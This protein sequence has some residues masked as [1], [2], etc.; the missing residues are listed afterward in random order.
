ML[1]I[2]PMLIIF[3][4]FLNEIRPLI[5]QI[6]DNRLIVNQ[7]IYS[8]KYVKIRHYILYVMDYF[9]FFLILQSVSILTC[10]FINLAQI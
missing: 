9:R 2:K 6:S 5:F 8:L 4:N 3:E 1:K 10:I 7:K